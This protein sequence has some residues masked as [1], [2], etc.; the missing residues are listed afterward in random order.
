[1]FGRLIRGIRIPIEFALDRLRA[2]AGQAQR[3]VQTFGQSVGQAA[4]QIN[5]RLQDAW[6]L[7]L[8]RIKAGWVAAA[9]AVKKAVGGLSDGVRQFAEFESAMMSVMVA[10]NA[11]GESM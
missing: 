1:M 5:K 9:A 11:A 2:T 6:N 8:G 4:S 3:I 10:A 7:D